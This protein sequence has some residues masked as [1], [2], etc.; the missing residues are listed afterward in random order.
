[1]IELKFNKAQ[2]NALSAIWVDIGKLVF[3]AMVVGYFLPTFV[4]AIRPLIMLLGVVITSLCFTIG[5]WFLRE[6]EEQ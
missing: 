1:M 5:L 3:A 2:R 6:E 4:G